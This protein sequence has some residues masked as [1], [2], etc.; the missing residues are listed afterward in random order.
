MK[1]LVG[2]EEW[3]EL[4]KWKN[5]E[6]KEKGR[7]RGMRVKEVVENARKGRWSEVEERRY[8]ENESKGSMER[9]NDWEYEEK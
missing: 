4:E 6:G 9:M 8:E 3:R 2:K 7:T 1:R 5:R